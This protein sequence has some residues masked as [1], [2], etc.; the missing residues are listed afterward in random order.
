MNRGRLIVNGVLVASL[1]GGGG[2]AWRS[3]QTSSTK[4]TITG[5]VERVRR[6]SLV[7]TVSASGN[8]ES[9]TATNV[10]FSQSG[11]VLEVAV[12]EGQVV[13]AG[14]VLARI[15]DSTQQAALQ[16]A[17]ASLSSAEERAKKTRS[18]L[19]AV[20]LDQNRATADQSK[21]SISTAEVSLTN[22]KASVVSNKRTYQLTI[23]QAESSLKSAEDALVTTQSKADDDNEAAQRSVENARKT[24]ELAKT[25][26]AH[27]N[28]VASSSLEIARSN[29]AHDDSVAKTAVE[30][31]QK[32]L[33][34]SIVQR[35]LYR[36]NMDNAQSSFDLKSGVKTLS[37][38]DTVARYTDAQTRCKESIT[39]YDEI[40]C[41]QASYLLSLAQTGQKQDSTVTQNQVSL[42]TALN[43]QISTA[44]KGRSNVTSA[45]NSV[46]STAEKGK[47]SVT[48]AENSLTTAVNSQRTTRAAG[49]Q[50]VTAAQDKIRSANDSVEN[51]KNNRST[52][53]LK[54]AQAVKNAEAS[55]AAAQK[56]Y[57]V[58]LAANRVKERPPTPDQTASDQ[59][60]IGS[61]TD[62]LKKAQENLND[63]ILRAPI[64]GTVASINGSVGDAITAG[65]STGAST[66]FL[67]LTDPNQLRIRVGFSEADALRI[68]VGQKAK[69]TM[70]VDSDRVFTGTV[71]SLDAT[72]TIVSNVVTYYATVNLVGDLEGVKVGM[73]A[74][75]DVTTDERDS[76]LQ[77]ATRAVKG[78]G[79]TATVIVRTKSKDASG[80]EVVEEEPKQVGVGLRADDGVEI[81]SGLTEG[82][83][84]VIPAATGGLPGGLRLPAGGPGGGGLG[85]GLR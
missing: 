1:I 30:A 81:T 31:A 36:N 12:R 61:A 77:L 20:E 85:G 27:D 63:T 41:T 66:P 76:V 82:Q 70:D 6:G 28:E 17:K 80:K 51:A 50:S 8:V 74:S 52:G 7:S 40:T 19:T 45:Q 42:T 62:Q 35:T 9:A 4:T 5:P 23:D 10:N 11:T 65:G 54:D 39:H 57:G 33:D 13:T 34:D 32:T 26:A 44:N 75:V 14:D 59:A 83:E 47:T 73:S 58:Q 72:Q 67:T 25:S 49:E 71:T 56:A 48:N 43:N 53:I 78:T 22:A 68:R 46:V 29:S 37:W 24:L 15:D 38:T 69:I 3:T 16:S 55:L 21:Q 84:V 2:F 64:D 60:T 79:K 18:G